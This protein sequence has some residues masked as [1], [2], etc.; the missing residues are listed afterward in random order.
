MES[1]H[2][3]NSSET[4]Y[5]PDWKKQGQ[6]YILEGEYWLDV[7]DMEKEISDGEP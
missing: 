6:H 5:I 3:R 4:D 1:V 7:F 2:L